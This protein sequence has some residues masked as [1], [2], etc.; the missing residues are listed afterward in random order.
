MHVKIGQKAR[1]GAEVTTSTLNM[2]STQPKKQLDTAGS[3]VSVYKSQTKL[4]SGMIIC[5]KRREL[6]AASCSVSLCNRLT[7][8]MTW[9]TERKASK[10]VVVYVQLGQMVSSGAAHDNTY[11]EHDQHT[12]QEAT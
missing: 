3:S 1:A 8:L 4:T 12:V 9:N 7:K 11:L 6:G 5:T 10:K 2:I